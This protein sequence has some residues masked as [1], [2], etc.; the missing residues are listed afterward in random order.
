MNKTEL[1][2]DIENNLSISGLCFKY[3]KAYSTIRYWLKKFNL[4]TNYKSFSDGGKCYTKSSQRKSFILNSFDWNEIQEFYNK[5]NTTRDIIKEYGVSFYS[6]KL[7]QKA[8]LFQP[9]TSLET[10]KMRDSYR[11]GS[12]RTSKEQKAE[13]GRKGGGY[14]HN[15]GRSKKSKVIDSYGKECTLQSSYELK[16]SKILD[17]NK[18]KWLRPSYLKY[19]AK[20]YY[21]DFYLPEFNIFF[22]T[23]NDYLIKQDKEKIEAVILENQVKLFVVGEKEIALEY[24]LETIEKNT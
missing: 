12:L 18:I 24:I 3:G 5:K 22:D 2:N 9:R 4:K 16:F 14:R 15:A 23:K 6:L 19:G 17:E 1:K 7:A 11:T 21:P 10:A 13:W 8:G 20:K